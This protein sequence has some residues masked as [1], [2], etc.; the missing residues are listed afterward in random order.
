MKTIL[1]TGASGLVGSRFVELTSSKYTILS[2]NHEE[3]D[4]TSRKSVDNFF[5]NHSEINTVVNFAAF[6]NVDAAEK[7]R[8]DENELCWKINVE[9]PKNLSEACR[10]KNIF[11]VHISTDFVFRGDE[12]YPGPYAEDSKLPESSEGIG[13]YG[14]TKLMAEKEINKL[15]GKFSIVRIA[16]PFRAGLYETKLDWARNN[17]KL[18]NEGKLYPLFTDQIQSVLFIDYLVEPLSKIIDDELTG[19]FH[20]VSSDTTTPFEIGSYLLERYTGKKVEI[21]KGS[22][23]EFLKAPGRTPRSIFGGLKTE[24]TQETLGMK[25]K[26]WK[27]AVDKFVSQLSTS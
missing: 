14:W 12:K 3:L 22:M 27:E 15:G 13:W 9:G 18:F 16:Y 21:Q 2:P 25:F 5:D 6:T 24:K 19:V 8:G 26:T 20:I 17:I 4:I 10:D 7:E 23:E 11:L 1:V